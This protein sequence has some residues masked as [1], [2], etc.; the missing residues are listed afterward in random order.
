[1]KKITAIILL[2]F[3]LSLGLSVLAGAEGAG[4]S[5][6]QA[7]EPSVGAE[8]ADDGTESADGGAENADGGAESTDGGNFFTAVFAAFRGYLPEILG[9][10]TFIGSLVL[11]FC[12]KRGLLP[13]VKASLSALSGVVGEVKKKAED[14]ELISRE[15]NNAVTERLGAAEAA[16]SSLTG[17][18]NELSDSLS[19]AEE[20]SLDRAKLTAVLTTQ[21][22]LLYDIFMSSSIPQ[23]QKELVGESVARMKEALSENEDSKS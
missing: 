22:D 21:I 18:L 5:P 20:R 4:E 10:L 23:F 9:T 1:M 17:S 11:A 19:A 2:T 16:L 7:V 14:G 15:L 3:I 12:Y 6:T 13:L 8:N